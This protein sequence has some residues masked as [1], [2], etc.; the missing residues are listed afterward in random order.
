MRRLLAVIFPVFLIAISSGVGMAL[1]GE[2]KVMDVRVHTSDNKNY[3]FSVTLK[4]ADSGWE[5]YANAWEILGPDGKV[6]GKRVLMHPHVNEQPFTRSLDNVQIPMHIKTIK[7]RAWDSKHGASRNTYGVE[8][9]G[10]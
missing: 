1:A 7:I 6:L 8:L 4:H 10:R 2:V 5:H 9:P 3:R